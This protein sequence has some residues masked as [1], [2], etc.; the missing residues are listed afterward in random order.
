MISTQK[1][2]RMLRDE[3]PE[4]EIS[5]TGGGHIKV[6]LPNGKLVFVSASPSDERYFL[7]NV[8]ADLKR[9][10]RGDQQ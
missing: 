8:K 1:I 6:A 9:A 5:F 10:L 4:A 7:Q 3:V 2:F